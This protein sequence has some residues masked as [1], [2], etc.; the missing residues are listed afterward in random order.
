M[1]NSTLKKNLVKNFYKGNVFSFSVGLIAVILISA[2]S[3]MIS[4]FMQVLIDLCT[5]AEGSIPLLNAVIYC[6]VG[7]GVFVF[8]QL[9]IYHSVP[10]FCSRAIRQYKEYAFLELS[11]KGIAAFNGENTSF[12]VSALSND[13]ATIENDYVKLVLTAVMNVFMFIGALL[14]ML[15]Y[16]PLL[17]A[18][19]VGL[20]LLPVV[21]SILAGNKMANAEKRVSVLNESYISTLN[22]GLIGF[23]VVKSFKAEKAMFALFSKRVKDVQNAKILRDKILIFIEALSTVA[24]FIAQI[25]VFIA[26][27]FMALNGYGVS[28]GV[29]IAFVNLMNFVLSPLSFLPQFFAKR[30]SA[31]ALVDKLAQKLNENVR[32]DG[33]EELNG[34]NGAI[35]L[36]NLSFSYEEGKEVLKNINFSFESGKSYAVVG[37]SGCGKSTLLN[38]INSAYSTYF[39][40]INYDGV[41]LKKIKSDSLYETVSL[42]QQNVFIFNASIRDNITMF[43]NFKEEEVERAIELSGLKELILRKGEDYLC[44]ENGNLLSGGEKQRISIARS[45]LKNSSVMLVDEATAALDQ[46]TSYHVISAILG[47]NG[48]TKI[49]VTHSLDSGVLS[50]YDAI[51]TLKNGEIAESG[52]FEELMRNKGYFYS[53]YTVSQ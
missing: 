53:L 14:L 1:K 23:S 20:S 17:T 18:I 8:G 34:L 15:W 21:T 16:S 3:V 29:V 51:L 10:K 22:D 41:E 11:K 19:S 25:G 27:A 45:L 28:A 36:K 7:L 37:A 5:G 32:E 43:S 50:R 13:V 48:I 9:L 40:E 24:G 12:Y 44:G 35:E 26:G 42:I 39:G 4:W 30:K 6:A 38:L 49:V 47:L 2:T 52:T 31:M 46:K 33:E